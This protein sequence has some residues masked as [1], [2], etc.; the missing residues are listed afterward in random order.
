MVSGHAQVTERRTRLLPIR[1]VMPILDKD[2]DQVLRLIEEGQLRWA[3]NV[4]MKKNRGA[5]ASLS[6][7]KWQPR[8]PAGQLTQSPL[9]K[10]MPLLT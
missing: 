9:R 10:L 1:A 8:W 2:E 3:F 6:F 7:G 4:A 5:N